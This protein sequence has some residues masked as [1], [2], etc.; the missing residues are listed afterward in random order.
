M[1]RTSTTSGALRVAVDATPLLGARTGIGHF[2]EGALAA[3]EERPGLDVRSFAVTWRGRGSVAGAQR[4]PM[5]ARV[6]RSLWRRADVPPL[7]WWTGTVDVV[8]G[9]N[10]VVPPARHAARVVSV[11][12]LSS[13]HH[14][15]WCND[16]TR[17]Y[18]QLI[19]RAVR[20]GAHV[21]VDSVVVGAQV[22]D[23]LGLG[24]ERVHVVHPGIPGAVARAVG[25][26]S[27]TSVTE[28]WPYVLALGTV[29]PRK[30]L[31]SLVAAFASL[32]SVHPDL[33]LVVA[34]P[35]GWGVGAYDAAVAALAPSA[36]S[37]VVRLGYVDD[38]RRDALVAG[39]RVFAYPSLDEGF[40]FPPLQAMVCG[41]AVVATAVGALPEVLGDGA[42]LVAPGDVEAL[43]AVIDRVVSDDA[44]RDA[45]AERGRA[46]AERFTWQACGDGLEAMYSRVAAQR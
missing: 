22:R 3:L 43:A 6:L 5:P 21:H 8:H 1:G 12:D 33:R 20:G 29:E 23:W 13:L 46:R 18:P 19:A 40:G 39:A 2:V 45:V 24:P 7:E 14:P 36:R 15:E 9:T 10:F 38:A 26:S 32:A 4:A 37:R 41:T 27:A 35:D 31:P 28:P 25:P 11:H 44:V 34:G 42:F 17:R 16:D 30:D